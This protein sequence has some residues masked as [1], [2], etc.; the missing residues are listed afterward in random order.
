MFV[1]ELSIS[2]HRLLVGSMFGNDRQISVLRCRGFELFFGSVFCKAWFW[3]VGTLCSFD[4]WNIY[5]WHARCLGTKDLVV[6]WSVEVLIFAWVYICKACFWNVGMLCFRFVFD[7]VDP[8]FVSSSS[9]HVLRTVRLEGLSNT[10][11][12]RTVV[13]K[14]SPNDKSHEQ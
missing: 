12:P 11:I 2:E 9:G 8:R 4:F 1:F 3:N 6:C 5:C 10:Q 13:L 7:S 14:G